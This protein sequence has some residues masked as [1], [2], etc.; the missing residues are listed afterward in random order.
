M[1]QISESNKR[2][3]LCIRWFQG[4]EQNLNQE[5]E[6]LRN[7]LDASQKKCSEIGNILITANSLYFEAL[8]YLKESSFCEIVYS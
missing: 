1:E 4:V 3:R 2:L 6:K 8:N 7:S 5:Q